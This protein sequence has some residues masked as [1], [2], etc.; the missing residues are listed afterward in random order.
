MHIYENRKHQHSITILLHLLPLLPGTKQ[1][2]MRLMSHL[3]AVL[4]LRINTAII[5]LPL[6]TLMACAGTT[7]SSSLQF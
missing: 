7:L 5:P 3:H 6:Y 2:G 1:L 4:R